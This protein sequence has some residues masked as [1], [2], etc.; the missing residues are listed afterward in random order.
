VSGDGGR[1]DTKDAMAAFGLDYEPEET[2]GMDVWEENADAASL[3]NIMQTQWVH[4]PGGRVSGINYASVF[5]MMHMIGI[6]YTE[7][8][9]T[10]YQF[11][12]MEQAGKEEINR[13]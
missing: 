12:V 4:R 13:G 3:F 2:P 8:Q 9:A 10:F 11:Q 1:D 6:G 5:D 7:R